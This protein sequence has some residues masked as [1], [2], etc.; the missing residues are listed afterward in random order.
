MKFNKKIYKGGF[1]NVEMNVM[2]NV[3]MKWVYVLIYV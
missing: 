3:C 1:E 2:I